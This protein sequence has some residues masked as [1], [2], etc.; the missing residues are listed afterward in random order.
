MEVASV[1]KAVTVLAVASMMTVR[2]R[3]WLSR[4]RGLVAG[5]AGVINRLWKIG[6]IA[7]VL[8]D[9]EKASVSA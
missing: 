4:R 8:E 6:D 1:E 2:V 7:K 5:A 3:A 9:W